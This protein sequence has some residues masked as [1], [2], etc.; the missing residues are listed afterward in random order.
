MKPMMYVSFA[1]GM[2]I[3]TTIGVGHYSPHPLDRLRLASGTPVHPNSHTLGISACQ[4]H[5]S[6]TQHLH[7]LLSATSTRA[8]TATHLSKARCSWK[9]FPQSCLGTGCSGSVRDTGHCSTLGMCSRAQ[10]RQHPWAAQA[11]QSPWW[12][13]DM[14]V[15]RPCQGSHLGYTSHS[16]SNSDLKQ[17]LSL[18]KGSFTSTKSQKSFKERGA[19]ISPLA[20]LPGGQQLYWEAPSCSENERCSWVSFSAPSQNLAH[21]ISSSD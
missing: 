19:V 13:Q 20:L 7:L 3:G 8:D 18:S 10:H 9:H 2:V 16:P 21:F 5:P 4:C 17:V 14:Q 12:V 15:R 1:V 6:A 11:A